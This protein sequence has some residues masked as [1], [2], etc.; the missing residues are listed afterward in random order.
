EVAAGTDQDSLVRQKR[1]TDIRCV[2][3]DGNIGLARGTELL[4]RP[5]A[6]I[7]AKQEIFRL[8][9]VGLAREQEGPV[10][11]QQKA[12][13]RGIDTAKV[14]GDRAVQPKVRVQAAVGEVARQDDV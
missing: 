13:G 4:I 11:L 7:V 3:A 14:G 6:G 5:A 1:E 8:L 2:Q 10:R 9:P 12:Q